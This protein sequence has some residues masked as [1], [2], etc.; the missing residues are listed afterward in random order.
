MEGNSVSP[1]G[2]EPGCGR[3]ESLGHT[4]GQRFPRKAPQ[5]CH[6]PGVMSC[7]VCVIARGVTTALRSGGSSAHRPLRTRP[8]GAQDLGLG[9]STAHGKDSFKTWPI[10]LR[11]G[12]AGFLSSLKSDSTCIA[13][14]CLS[15]CLFLVPFFGDGR[16]GREGC[17]Y[18][19]VEPSGCLLEK[20]L[21]EMCFFPALVPLQLAIR[22]TRFRGRLCDLTPSWER[23]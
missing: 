12:V 21:K 10:C 15:L 18:N 3:L 17:I 5:A 9:P 1:S 13:A 6:L 14:C 20:N 7:H 22:R 19:A 16:C 2:A 23:E 4:N 8:P 11:A